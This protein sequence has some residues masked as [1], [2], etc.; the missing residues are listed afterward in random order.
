MLPAWHA[1][2]HR[3]AGTV[4]PH[5]ERQGL[6][7]LDDIL[8][9]RAEGADALDEHLQA[10]AAGEGWAAWHDMQRL[11]RARARLPQAVCAR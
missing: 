11:R 5:Y 9:V 8:V 10:G 1:G 6:V 7:E 2:A 3:F 4:V